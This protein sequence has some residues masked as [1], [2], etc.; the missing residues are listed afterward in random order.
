MRSFLGNLA[1]NPASLRL[2]NRL[3]IGGLIAVIAIITWGK[4]LLHPSRLSTPPQMGDYTIFIDLAKQTLEQ[5]QYPPSFAYPVPAVLMWH[6]FGSLNF[7][8][9][10]LVWILILPASLFG[11]MLLAKSLAGD[12]KKHGGLILALAFAAVEYYLMWDLRAINANSCYLLLVMLGCWCWH[13]DQKVWAGVLLGGSV[14][15]KFYSVVFIGY[16]ILRKEWRM[17]LAMAISI[18]VLFIAV[19]V[20]VLGV[21]DA[22]LL[23]EAWIQRILS[24]S[25][26]SVFLNY[27]AYKVSLN[28]IALVLL[29]P[30]LSAG[31]LNILDWSTDR[32]AV[33]V[34]FL[35]ATW[36][37]MVAG[38]FFTTQ[39]LRP[40]RVTTRLAFALDISVLLFC[41]LPASPILEPHHLVVMVVPAIALICM[42]FDPSFHA[43]FRLVAGL[44]VVMGACLTE[45]GPRGPLRGVGVM[46]TLL[47]YLIGLWFLRYFAFG[48]TGEPSK[49]SSGTVVVG[50]SGNGFSQES[51]AGI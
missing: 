27:R 29:N 24:A 25:N 18:L 17:G 5:L 22:F 14:A 11:S 34:R 9:G 42:V 36:A 33:V 7:T 41:P 21:Q 10:A 45:F 23:S 3:C 48:Q 51:N 19:P 26:S 46:L 28:W 39:L 35:G 37:L 12:D 6:F 44:T 31:K 13:K 38:Y 47:V 4:T 1:Q 32:I 2:A 8:V 30:D 43:R 50:G 16:L 40:G 49:T 20:C 15:F